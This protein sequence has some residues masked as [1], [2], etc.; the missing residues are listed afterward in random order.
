MTRRLFKSILPAASRTLAA[1]ILSVVFIAALS[2]VNSSPA[3][4]WTTSVNSSPGSAP[5]LNPIVLLVTL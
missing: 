4:T 1:G 2:T 5:R 3:N